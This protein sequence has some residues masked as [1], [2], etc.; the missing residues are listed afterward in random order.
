[1]EI[2]N[3]V[4]LAGKKILFQ[5][6]N[7]KGAPKTTW[8]TQRHCHPAFEMHLI[9]SGHCRVEA[10]RSEFPLQSGNA[11]LIPPGKYHRPLSCSPDFS[12]YNLT[13]S[14][15]PVLRHRLCALFPDCTVIPI[16]KE[17]S[18]LCKSLLLENAAANPYKEERINALLT[19]LA[20]ELFRLMDVP[21]TPISK[22]LPITDLE[23]FSLID[24][25]FEEHF[26]DTATE[27][28]L[29]KLL[30]LSKRQ[31]ARVLEKHYGMSFRQ[32]RIHARMDRATWLLRATEHTISY[33]AGAVGYSSESTFFQIFRRHF[34]I[35]P[36]QYRLKNK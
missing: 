2:R 22:T 12:R 9:L 26:A 3:E 4:F 7:S 8:D 33:I 23:R 21:D 25:F 1:M 30:H 10:E 27:E 31:L 24:N 35:T 11:L 16:T 14:P 36:Q 13:F 29:A 17:A 5:A 20:A 34:G 15:D 32:K 28:D 19:L 6:D 18:D